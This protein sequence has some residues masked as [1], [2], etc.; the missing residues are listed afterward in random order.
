MHVMPISRLLLQKLASSENRTHEIKVGSSLIMRNIIL[1]KF[2]LRNQ[3]LLNFEA[4]D[5]DIDEICFHV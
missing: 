3:V 4:S 1:Q 5:C 2:M